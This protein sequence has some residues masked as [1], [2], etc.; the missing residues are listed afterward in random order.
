MT[1]PT[2][3]IATD[4]SFRVKDCKVDDIPLDLPAK[5]DVRTVSLWPKFMMDVDAMVTEPFD[6]SD[7]NS[8]IKVLY[9]IMVSYF[10]GK[11]PNT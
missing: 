2:L 10:L 1:D 7:K 6:N 5:I 8:R 9:G 11:N 3:K 4:V